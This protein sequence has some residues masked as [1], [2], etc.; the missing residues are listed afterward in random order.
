MDGSLGEFGNL[1]WLPRAAVVLANL[2]PD[3]DGIVRVPA[4][5]LGDGHFVQVLALDGDQA[6]AVQRVRAEQPLQPRSRQL[7]KALDAQQHFA[8]QKRIEFVAAGGTAKL[9]DARQA[10]VEIHDSLASVFRLFTTI[11]RDGELAKFAFVLQWPTLD[12]AAKIR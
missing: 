12:A 4:N 10:Q 3:K 9:E 8:E 11:S 7:P 5:E 2:T 1:D 6:V